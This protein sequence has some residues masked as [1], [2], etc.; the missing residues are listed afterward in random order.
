[1]AGPGRRSATLA[2]AVLAALLLLVALAFSRDLRTWARSADWTANADAARYS[3][4]AEGGAGRRGDERE[5]GRGGGQGGEGGERGR[6]GNEEEAVRCALQPDAGAGADPRA[7]AGPGTSASQSAAE[8]AMIALEEPV[9]E[10]Q[11]TVDYYRGVEARKAAFPQ[12]NFVFAM[13]IVYPPFLIRAP[14]VDDPSDLV[15][16]AS[17]PHQAQYLAEAQRWCEGAGGSESE[18][19]KR[20]CAERG[21][22]DLLYFQHPYVSG[23]IDVFDHVRVGPHEC[24]WMATPKIATPLEAGAPTQ[25]DK[26]ASLDVPEGCAFQHFLDGVLPKIVAALPVIRDPEVKL[27]IPACPYGDFVGQLYEHLGIDRSRLVTVSGQVSVRRFYS[28]CD[29]PGWNPILW[30]QMR[31]AL[32]APVHVPAAER[33]RVVYLPRGDDA[34][35]GRPVQNDGDVRAAVQAAAERHGYQYAVFDRANMPT[36][37][38]VIAFFRGARLIVGMH[39]G[40]FYNMMFAPAGLDVVEFIPHSVTFFL[41]HIMADMLGNR[42]WFLPSNEGSIPVDKLTRILDKALGT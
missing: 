34:R 41:F 6:G 29:I 14:N 3:S 30:Q 12:Q 36:V 42:H 26:L 21:P 22:N 31:L 35:N 23:S 7:G 13:E 15:A 37:A 18:L 40:A 10:R 1:M 17:K 38:D 8:N 33:T 5:R 19:A 2:A 20:L 24:G 16:W 39:G 11:L 28:V 4:D 32:G 9:A 25:Y 27:W